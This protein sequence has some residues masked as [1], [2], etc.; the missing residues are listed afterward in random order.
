MKNIYVILGAFSEA[1]AEGAV[2]LPNLMFV[3]LYYEHYGQIEFVMPFVLLYAF[4]KAGP[5]LLSGFGKLKNPYMVWLS[6]NILALLGCILMLCGEFNHFFWNLGAVVIGLGLSCFAP[7]YRTTRDALREKKIWSVG[8]SLYIGYL[9]LGI[10][11]II[12]MSFRYVNMIAVISAIFFLVLLSTVQ[13][14]LLYKHNPYKDIP[15]WENKT[16][17]WDQFLLALIILL[18]TYVIRLYKQTASLGLVLW[19]I[20]GMILLVLTVLFTRKNPYRGHSLRTLWYGA[21]RNFVTIFSLIYFMAIGEYGKV[22]IAYL[23]IGVGV[24]LSKVVSPIMKKKIPQEKF[25]SI[26]IILASVFSCLMLIPNTI[27][28][29]VGV[30]LTVVFVAI[31]NSSSIAEYLKDERFSFEERR[32]VRSR[33]YGLGAV[34]EQAVMMMLFFFFSISDMGGG[35][36]ALAAYTFRVA[37]N[38]S[39]PVFF[40]SLLACIVVNSVFGLVVNRKKI[41]E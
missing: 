36:D 28:Y 30:M 16:V 17:R 3:G 8:L 39:R 20:M 5:F 37:D 41:E 24:S 12:V 33:F 6:G 25:E 7:C 21:E 23:M 18:F 13:C 9:I 32:L 2:M 14:M 11:L 26:C 35:S 29:M 10:Y 19:I 1:L 31:G 4:E 15:V 38:Q 40:W 34:V 27:S 22:T